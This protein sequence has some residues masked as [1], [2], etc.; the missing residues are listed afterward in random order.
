VPE[1]LIWFITVIAS[2]SLALIDEWIDLQLIVLLMFIIQGDILVVMAN[3]CCDCL[4]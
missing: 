1:L 4:R 2:F 3:C